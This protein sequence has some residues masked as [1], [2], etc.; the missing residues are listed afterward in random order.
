M[1]HGLSLRHVY[2]Q[3]TACVTCYALTQ[4]RLR[5]GYVT[6]PLVHLP[7]ELTLRDL[8]LVMV[9][10]TFRGKLPVPAAKYGSKLEGFA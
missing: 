3:Q 9:T 7:T 4:R 10:R 8:M 6:L 2:S 5:I 1:T